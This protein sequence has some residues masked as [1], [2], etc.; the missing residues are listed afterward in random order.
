MPPALAAFAIFAT[1]AGSGC[2][3]ELKL[4][5]DF[6]IHLK[7]SNHLRQKGLREAVDSTD[8]KLPEFKEWKLLLLN[9]LLSCITNPS[10]AF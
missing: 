6:G 8:I 4:Q 10:G 1:Y 5:V 7:R 2:G 9:C 3:S